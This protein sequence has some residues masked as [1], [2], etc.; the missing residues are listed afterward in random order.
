MENPPW[1]IWKKDTV[2]IINSKKKPIKYLYKKD[3]SLVAA[4]IILFCEKNY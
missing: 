1:C 2:L 4:T 3:T